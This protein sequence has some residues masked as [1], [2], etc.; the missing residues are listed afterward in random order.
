MSPL[1]DRRGSL[2]SQSGRV[3]QVPIVENPY[4]LGPLERC[5]RRVQRASNLIVVRH[6]PRRF[7]GVPEEVAQSFCSITERMGAAGTSGGG[8]TAR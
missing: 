8:H 1:D 7:T 6:E 5:Q 4:R 2:S 3:D